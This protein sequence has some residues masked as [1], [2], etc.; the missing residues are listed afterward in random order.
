MLSFNECFRVTRVLCKLY[1]K[2]F[3][4]ILLIHIKNQDTCSM[5]QNQ[6]DRGKR[7]F[8]LSSLQTC[9]PPLTDKD[10]YNVAERIPPSSLTKIALHY[11]DMESVEIDQCR[12]TIMGGGQPNQ[13]FHFKCLLR[14]KQRKGSSATRCAL[15]EIV[16]KAADEGLMERTR[17][18]YLQDKVGDALDLLPA[19][20]IATHQVVGVGTELSQF[21]SVAQ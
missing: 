6:H 19:R 4:V 5:S 11:L 1:S 18:Q 15:Y 3:S 20:R 9:D 13:D 21:A 12:A 8:M 14:W 7:F 2:W 10:L 17:L 16:D